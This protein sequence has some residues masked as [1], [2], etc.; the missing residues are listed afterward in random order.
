[1]KKVVIFGAG[2]VG[3]ILYSYIKDTQ[4]VLFFVDNNY[5]YPPPIN[6]VYCRPRFY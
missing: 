5:D 1:M 2:D 6:C 3:Q 4:E